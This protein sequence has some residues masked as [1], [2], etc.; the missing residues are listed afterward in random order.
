MV[1]V[2]IVAAFLGAYIG[3]RLLEKVTLRFMQLVVAAL[4]IIIGSG[5]VSGLL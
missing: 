2:A 4:M 3:V 5:L 1:V